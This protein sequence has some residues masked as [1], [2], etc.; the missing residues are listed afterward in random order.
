MA[1]T[2][3][4]RYIVQVELIGGAKVD[5]RM[6]VPTGKNLLG[7][8]HDELAEVGYK[9]SDI[10]AIEVVQVFAFKVSSDILN[11]RADSCY[12]ASKTF[13]AASEDDARKQA[14]EYFSHEPIQ[15]FIVSMEVE[16]LDGE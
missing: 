5:Y 14:E 10:L 11:R 16:R 3:V 4:K 6:D 2:S 12:K 8:I 9:S 15:M 7:M 1:I 13:Y